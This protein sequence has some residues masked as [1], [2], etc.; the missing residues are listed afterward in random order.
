MNVTVAKVR[1]LLRVF[2]LSKARIVLRHLD[3][4][5]TALVGQ[6]SEPTVSFVERHKDIIAYP[7]VGE[8]S[9]LEFFAV[10]FSD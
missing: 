4:P 1:A 7:R 9:A 10:S 3:Q 6:R 8:R 5:S 2:V